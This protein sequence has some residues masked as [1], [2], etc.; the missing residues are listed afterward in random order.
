MLIAALKDKKSIHDDMKEKLC[1]KQLR[2]NYI[3]NQK[4]K[5]Q[6]KNTSD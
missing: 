5:Q 2:L 3:N 1:F 6:K 4:K